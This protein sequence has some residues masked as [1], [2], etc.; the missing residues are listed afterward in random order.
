M[1]ARRQ[2]DA[3]AVLEKIGAYAAGEL[4]GEEIRQAEQL[5][6]DRPEYRRPA[7][8]YARM[9]SCSTLRGRGVRRRRWWSATPSGGL[10]VGLP[11]AGGACDR[12]ACWETSS[13]PILSGSRPAW[14]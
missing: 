11:E 14:Q 6:F 5:I 4:E 1:S 8:S 9:L 13:A 7:E 2:E 10:H 12:F 3:R